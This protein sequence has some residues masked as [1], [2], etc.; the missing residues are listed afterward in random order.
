MDITK[1][2][3]EWQSLG[4]VG[5][6]QELGNMTQFDPLSVFVQDFYTLKSL[7]K[8]LKEDNIS[9]HTEIMWK[10]NFR[11]QNVTGTQSCPFISTIPRALLRNNGSIE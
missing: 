5:I 2:R 7:R 6:H 8:K 3:G 10:S 1:V 4:N 11:I 9:W